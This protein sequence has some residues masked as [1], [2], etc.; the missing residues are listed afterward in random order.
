M[1]ALPQLGT[2]SPPRHRPRMNE[3]DKR[4]GLSRAV[5]EHCDANSVL[6][7]CACALRSINF[8][9]T[10]NNIGRCRGTLKLRTCLLRLYFSLANPCQKMPAFHEACPERDHAFLQS[11]SCSYKFLRNQGPDI[12]C[13]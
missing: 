7:Y 2:K 1:L 8:F 3:L 5:T 12:F 4:G 9:P 11:G 13:R 6:W 10:A